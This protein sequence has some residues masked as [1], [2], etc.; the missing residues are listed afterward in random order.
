MCAIRSK[1]SKVLLAAK[2]TTDNDVHLTQAFCAG[3]A[4]GTVSQHDPDW[5]RLSCQ[6]LT[7]AYPKG[8]QFVVVMPAFQTLRQQ[9]FDRIV[10]AKLAESTADGIVISTIWSSKVIQRCCPSRFLHE[11]STVVTC[12]GSLPSCTTAYSLWCVVFIHYIATNLSRV[13]S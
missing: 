3:A 5:F 8:L 9:T 7:K 2:C 12:V 6:N 4:S 10:K 1:E 11:R 13:Q